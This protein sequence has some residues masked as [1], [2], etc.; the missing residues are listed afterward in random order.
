MA[1]KQV[2][3][4]HAKLKLEATVPESTAAVLAAKGW[5][6]GPLSTRKEA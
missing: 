2:V 3:I 1:T 4:H 5:K 6:S